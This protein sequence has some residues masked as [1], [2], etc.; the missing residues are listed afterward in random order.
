MGSPT[1]EDS[2]E[3]S[4]NPLV[5]RS[6]YELDSQHVLF[7]SY[8]NRSCCPELLIS[9]LSPNQPIASDQRPTTRGSNLN[10]SSLI[11]SRGSLYSHYGTMLKEGD[12]S[13]GVARL[14]RW[15]RSRD[16]CDLPLVPL[17]ML[18][19]ASGL[20]DWSMQ[21][22]GILIEIIVCIWCIRSCWIASSSHSLSDSCYQIT[23]RSILR[24][25]T[26]NLTSRLEVE[27]KD[28]ESVG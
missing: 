15:A 6:S 19:W 2:A 23:W 14:I 11:H 25:L 7:E 13:M 18:R 4:A 9:D 5:F 16:S 17:C 28:L 22:F 20:T 21:W 1:N 10:C 12:P 3:L 8:P 24:F 26:L 27:A